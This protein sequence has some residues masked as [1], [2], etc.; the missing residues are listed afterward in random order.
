MFW[1]QI[2]YIMPLVTVSIGS[3][4]L[5]RTAWK[6]RSVAGSYPFALFLGAIA[7]W[8]LVYA[9]E[10]GSNELSTKLFWY[11]AKYL[12]VIAVPLAALV[13]TLQFVGRQKLLT[14][15]NYLLSCL[16]PFVSIAL[17]W[18]NQQHGLFLSD[19][20]M[21]TEPIPIL[22]VKY[23]PA[24]WLHTAYCYLV[25]LISIGLLLHAYIS[26]SKQL[27]RQ[28][29]AAIVI[30]G[31][32]PWIGNVL[33]LLELSPAPNLDL[34]PFLFA[35]TGFAFA[36]ALLRYELLNI[37]PMARDAIINSM[38][39]GVIVL[40]A[41]NRVV[42]LNPAAH[43]ILNELSDSVSGKSLTGLDAQQILQSVWPNLVAYLHSNSKEYSAVVNS[44]PLKGQSR[45]FDI[46]ISPLFT[47]R[48]QFSGRL[49]TIHESTERER[50]ADALRQR[51]QQLRTMVEKLH[52][53]DQLKSD[54][55]ANI[56]HE[57]RT[58]LTNI[59]FYVNLLE[60]TMHEDQE[61]YIRV[62]KKET[63]LLQEMIEKTL[64]MSLLDDSAGYRQSYTEP[65]NLRDVVRDVIDKHTIQAQSVGVRIIPPEEDEPVFAFGNYNQLVQAINNLLQ[66]A[67]K[68][69]AKNGTVTIDLANDTN[70]VYIKVQDT[71]IGIAPEDQR[72][73]FERFYRSPRVSSSGIPGVGLGLSIVKELV[74]QNGGEIEVQSQ[75]DVGSLFTI[76]LPIAAAKANTDFV[77]ANGVIPRHAHRYT[78]VAS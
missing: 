78:S 72:R 28:Q 57:L 33:T 64:D 39:D 40:S 20:Q 47:H 46:H 38:N 24:F 41:Q 9:L 25:F 29:I 62:L 58:P 77:S 66:N 37:I 76:Q 4:V 63:A 65:V 23:G 69:S 21:A 51:K 13:F 5:A 30:G 19:V 7:A 67:I 68:Y 73:L 18:T 6:N 26:R 17:L 52:K 36:W 12:F 27:S 48:S 75:V 50:A 31:S 2:I 32:A 16:I 54:F 8:S 61:N 49:I 70:Y 34:T 1:N 42:D 15:R 55:I 71:G 44:N 53:A 56:S 43:R 45:Y 59:G 14:R 35:I 22:A 3:F 74:K 11:K 60:R 10:I